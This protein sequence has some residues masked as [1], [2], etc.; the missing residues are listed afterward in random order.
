MSNPVDPAA[1][2]KLESEAVACE[3]QNDFVGALD[4]YEE[5]D[6]NGWSTPRHLLALGECYMRARQRQN[7][8]ESWLRAWQ[9]DSSLTDVV[10]LLD[11]FFPGWEKTVARRQNEEAPPPPPAFDQAPA[12][13]T[14][15]SV[16]F[17]TPPPVAP[18][19]P[20]PEP[21]AR[22]QQR[23]STLDATMLS[24]QSPASPGQSFSSAPPPIAPRH[25]PN[26]PVQQLRIQPTQVVIEAAKVVVGGEVRESKVN[27][28]YIM[29]DAAEE[30]AKQRIRPGALRGAAAK[31]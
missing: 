25:A 6:R 27:W 1:L 19:V 15:E 23:P 12:E 14:V 4:V 21:Q 11:R 26:A 29:T 7:A 3:R 10:T 8:R 20:P 31:P 18:A 16:S 9:A 24:P 13:L 2:K 17:R 30:T 22:K 5:I 28:G